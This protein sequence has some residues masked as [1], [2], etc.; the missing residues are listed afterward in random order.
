MVFGHFGAFRQFL[1]H[2]V[3]NM[4]HF[5]ELVAVRAVERKELEHL[6]LASNRLIKGNVLLAIGDLG[7]GCTKS[8]NH[9]SQRQPNFFHDLL[10]PG[11]ITLI[12]WR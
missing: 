10:S 12:H 11:Y 5:F 4:Q 3:R 1:T 2:I 8:Q 7:S 9:T 6:R